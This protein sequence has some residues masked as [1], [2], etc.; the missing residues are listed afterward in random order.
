M[1]DIK[2]RS[3]WQDPNMPVKGPAMVLRS[4]SMIPA[5][6]TAAAK[7]M[8]DTP[9]YLR[10]I[11]RDYTVN[12]GYSIGYNFAIDQDGIAWELRGF[13]IKCAA[14]RGVNDTTIAVLCLVDGAEAMNPAMVATF[15]A[16]AAE[17]QRRTVQELV[18]VGHRDIGATACPGN[19]IYAQVV[20]GQLDPPEPNIPPSI[21][22]PPEIPSIPTP[23][24]KP[25]IQPG[26]DSMTI[27]IFESQTNPKEFNAMF[28]AECDSKD[29][30]IELQCSG[31]GDDPRV[32]ER[33]K[34]MMD[35]FG[36]ALPLLL[37]GVKNN[38]LH[39]KHK[40]SDIN[41]SAKRG[42]WTEADFAP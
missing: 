36:P 16:L 35:N 15:K 25:P 40:P 10:L 29:R 21:P 13:D 31:S 33:I 20:S 12:R 17:A 32:Q 18:V 34:V 22:I 3:A 41:D 24:Q 27:R 4:I 42:G 39:P 19:G 23:P 2:P 14:N 38:R 6:Y 11:H 5:H 26:D 7:V 8:R 1:V 28:F 30:S 37:A 9:A